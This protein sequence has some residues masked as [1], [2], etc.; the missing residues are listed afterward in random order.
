MK[1]RY[2]VAD[3]R[4][5]PFRDQPTNGYTY[6]GAIMRVQREIDTCIKLFGGEADDYKDGYCVLDS[7]FKEV[8]TAKE[9]F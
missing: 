9:A 5:I 1:G 3:Y 6:L 7:K 8:K 4:G 2:F